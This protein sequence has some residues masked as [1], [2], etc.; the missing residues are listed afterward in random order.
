[1]VTVQNPTDY[2]LKGFRKTH[3]KD[4]KV[5][6]VLINKKNGKEKSIPFGLKGSNTY[7]NKTG[8]SMSDPTHGDPVKRA[9]YRK[10]HAGENSRKF[11][12]GYFAYHYLW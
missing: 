2:R 7:C 8:I 6:A 1:M 10:R 5:E 11:S 9:N 12:S 3:V 4:K